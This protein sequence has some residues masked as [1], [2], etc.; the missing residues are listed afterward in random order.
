MVL[1]YKEREE[2]KRFLDVVLA[3]TFIT[4]LFPVAGLI[5]LTLVLERRGPI[6]YRQERLGRNRRPFEI[7]K[8]RT[9][10]VDAERDSGPVWASAHDP[11]VTPVG[12][13]L[14]AS[15]LDEL[16]QLWNVLRGEMSLV[17]PR[18]ER[19]HFVAQFETLVPGYADRFAARPGITGLSQIRSGY[20]QSIST[21]RKKIRYDRFYVR[22]ACVL[23]DLWLLMGTIGYLSR[24]GG[25]ALLAPAGGHVRFTRRSPAVR[26]FST[27]VR[28][29]TAHF[30][31]GAIGAIL[32]ALA[33]QVQA[34][35][36]PPLP[37]DGNGREVPPR[38]PQAETSTYPWPGGA[39][40][41]ES[42]GL[43]SEM[44]LGVESRRIVSRW[45]RETLFSNDKGPH[46]YRDGAGDGTKKGKGN[47]KGKGGRPEEPGPLVPEPEPVPVPVPI[48]IPEPLPPEPL[49]SVV[50]EPAPAS[51]AE[52]IS[53]PSAAFLIGAGLLWF[54]RRRAWQAASNASALREGKNEPF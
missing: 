16:P 12:R 37:R 42:V 52:P 27:R 11:R 28:R 34:S 31:I 38:T 53:E 20:D 36:G 32:A 7:L 18:P 17:G 21:V 22:R 25:G 49:P 19:S 54:S 40:M 10:G 51:T 44:D 45:D 9:M 15:H 26:N 48:P 39:K 4:L 2:L 33:L 5:A 35:P 8:F 30:A 46:G 6:L 24:S 14:R 43:D 1:H 41:L 3:A 50:V 47:G 29:L 23:L 13:F